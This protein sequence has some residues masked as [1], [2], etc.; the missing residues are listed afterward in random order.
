[1][2]YRYNCTD[3]GREFSPEVIEQNS[4]YLCP[5]CGGSEKNQPLSGVLQILYDYQQILNKIS[6]KK[7][8][9]LSPG[10]FWQYP[11]LW[12]LAYSETR[13]GFQMNGLSDTLLNR[14]SLN[15]NPFLK[16]KYNEPAHRRISNI[17]LAND[18]FF[19]VLNESGSNLKIIS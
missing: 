11:W 7:F 4:L 18:T 6:R 17:E 19:P 14:L 5:R 9:T 8:L 13:S 15:T 10:K 16:Y 1:M 3:C 12:P 2:F